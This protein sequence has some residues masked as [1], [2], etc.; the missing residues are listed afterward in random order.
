MLY[1]T[2]S[3]IYYLCLLLLHKP[4]R[5]D[6]DNLMYNPVHV[7]GEPIVCASY[8]QLTNTHDI[9]DSINKVRLTFEHV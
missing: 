7:G 6:K 2:S 1:R 5:G 8:Q 9:V 4:S 3:D